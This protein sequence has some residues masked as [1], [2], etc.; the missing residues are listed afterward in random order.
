FY[1]DK[2]KTDTYGFRSEGFGVAGGIERGSTLGAVGVTL[3]FTSSDIEDPEAEAQEI[4][5]ASLVELGLSWRAQGQ[6]W[7]TW[8]RAAGGYATFDSTRQ[9]VTESVNLINQSSWNGFT[10][11]LAGGASYERNFGRLSIRPEAFV[12]YFSLSEDG[13]AEEGV[14]SGFNL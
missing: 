5:S 1:A 2:D 7:S 14:N 13:H 12:E 4:L 9:L 8:A 11:A 10:L 6:A 3:A